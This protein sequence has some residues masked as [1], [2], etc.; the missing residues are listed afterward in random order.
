M[1]RHRIRDFDLPPGVFRRR[2]RYYFG[3]DGIALGGP[4][5][6]FKRY[7]ELRTGAPALGTFADAAALYSRDEL[8]KKAFKT[9]AEYTRQLVTLVRVF[10][11]QP[12][13]D[14]EPG[15]VRD[16]L[17]RRPRIAG[18]RDKAL[19]SAV[20]NFARGRHLTNAPNPCAG[21]RGHKATRHRYVT[22]AELDATIKAAD[23]LLAD[24][25]RLCYLTGQ[26]PSDVLRM[27]PADV[28][29]GRLRV[30]Q[31]KTGAQVR[32]RLV[33]PLAAIYK[34]LAKGCG[35]LQP[36]IRDAEGQRVLLA[37]M[38]R[39]LIATGA[40][41]QIR[42][43]RAKAGSDLPELRAAKELLG[44]A[45]ETTTDAYRRSRMGGAAE[46]VMRRISDRTKRRR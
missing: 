23:S 6:W 43:L 44:H 11:A 17:D 18:T 40:N 37:T 4:A 10:G 27:C 45:H 3:K 15:D 46:P 9:Q 33:G 14:I 34:R 41:W 32:I 7:S 28:H 38:R 29:D 12:L 42:D 26:R 1:G 2:D 39:R 31:G 16:F 5:E 21:I 30:R 22:D 24:F 19:L 13:G 35:A 36:L 20:F 8:R 25:L